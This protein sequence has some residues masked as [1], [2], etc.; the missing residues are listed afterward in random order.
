MLYEHYKL[1]C[2][3]NGNKI[4]FKDFMKGSKIDYQLF[5]RDTYSKGRPGRFS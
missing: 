5:N 1:S 4:I 2:N 3:S